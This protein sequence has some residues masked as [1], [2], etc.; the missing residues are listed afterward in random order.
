MWLSPNLD[1]GEEFSTGADGKVSLLQKHKYY[2][3][4]LPRMPVKLERAYKKRLQVQL[5]KQRDS[6]HKAEGLR[7][8]LVEGLEV[9]AQCYDL[10]WCDDG[11][12]AVTF[13]DYDDT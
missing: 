2:N 1:C 4:L 8:Q 13:T 6:D 3:T 10:K 7:Q 5:I 9:R 12:F 11:S